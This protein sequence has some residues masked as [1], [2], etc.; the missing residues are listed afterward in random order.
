MQRL[1][2][3][4]STRESRGLSQLELSYRS[5]VAQSQI[6]KLERGLVFARR[7]TIRKLAAALECRQ[8]E[9]IF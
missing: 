9:I 3:L 2:G 5:G 6:S 7:A 4:R 1:D 8:Y